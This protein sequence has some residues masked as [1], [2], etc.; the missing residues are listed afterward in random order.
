VAAAELADGQL[1]AARKQYEQAVAADPGLFEAR[2]GLAILEQDAGRAAASYE[3]AIAAIDSAPS[4]VARTAARAL[5][6]SVARFAH[7]EASDAVSWNPAS[8][9]ARHGHRDTSRISPGG[10]P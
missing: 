1:D 7:K 4:E 6:S 5:A 2:Y 9:P 3:H 10:T 8:S